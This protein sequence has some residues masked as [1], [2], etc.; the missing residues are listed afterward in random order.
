[1]SRLHAGVA[2][3]RLPRALPSAKAGLPWRA[4][5]PAHLLDTAAQSPL[6]RQLAR[7]VE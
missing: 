3:V 5:Q 4:G 6:A 2:E 7:E 1:M